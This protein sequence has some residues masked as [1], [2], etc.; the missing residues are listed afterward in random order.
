MDGQRAERRYL[1][2]EDAF[3]WD[4][5]HIK[6]GYQSARITDVSRNGMRLE[7]SER[8]MQGS[9]VAID[10]RG[11]IIC[12]SVQYCRMIENRFAIGIRIKDV[13][14]PLREEPTGSSANEEVCV[15]A[16]VVLA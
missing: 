15:E 13:L 3:V 11:M 8:L 10:F 5:R 12:G 6:A 16:V 1:V 14:D 7:L 2:K 4:L 9:Q